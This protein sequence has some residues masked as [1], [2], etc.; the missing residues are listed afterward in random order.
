M[1]RAQLPPSP[2]P[3]PALSSSL[4]RPSLIP[5][6]IQTSSGARSDRESGEEDHGEGCER[7]GFWRELGVGVYYLLCAVELNWEIPCISRNAYFRG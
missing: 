1:L 3:P 2:P 4:L 7:G 5:L 6:P